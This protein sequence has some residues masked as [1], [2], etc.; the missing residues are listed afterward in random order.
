M[1]KLWL[2]RCLKHGQSKTTHSTLEV[3]VRKLSLSVFEAKFHSLNLMADEDTQIM[4]VIGG[5]RVNP[6]KRWKALECL[7]GLVINTLR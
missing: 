3:P 2:S 5:G 4:V 1:V 7:G 6:S